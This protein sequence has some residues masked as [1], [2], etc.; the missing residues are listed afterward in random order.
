MMGSQPYLKTSTFLCA[1]GPCFTREMIIN[2]ITNV[3]IDANNATA[4]FRCLF[5]FVVFWGG[6]GGCRGRIS[7][8]FPNP[9]VALQN[10]C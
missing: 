7:L 9:K 1:R 2:N 6:G 3:S 8:I 5:F 10:N 4:L